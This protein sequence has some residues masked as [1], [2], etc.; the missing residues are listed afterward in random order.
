MFAPKDSSPPVSR[1]SWVSL[2]AVLFVQTQNAFNDN[3]VKFVLMGLAMAVAAGSAIGDNIEFVLAALIP[4]PF[5]LLAPVAGFLSDRFSKK[6]V[7][8]FCLLLQL[9]L[10]ILIG[11]AI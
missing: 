7:I 9:L 2:G 6:D 3:F 5:I 1:R 10:F 4:L 11:A 8:W